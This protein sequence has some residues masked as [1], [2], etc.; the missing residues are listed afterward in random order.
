MAE[1][2]RVPRRRRH[3]YRPMSIAR[4]LA[5]RPRVLLAVVA[6]GIT[7]LLLPSRLPS[8]ISTAIAGDVAA[9]VYL[10]FALHAMITHSADKLRNRAAKEDDGAVVI[11]V[12][13]LVTIALSFGS[14]FGVLSEAKQ[15]SGAARAEHTALAAATILLSWLVTQVVFTFHYAHEFYRP[16]ERGEPMCSGLDFPKDG[17]PDYWDFFYFATSFGAASQ[18]S[19]VAISGKALRRIATLHAIVSFFFNTAVLALAINIGASLI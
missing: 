3:W 7:A 12:I 10:A 18:T 1:Q 16:D 2:P 19:D 8:S 11:L 13:V 17:K 6:G 14:I 9:L 4:S 5:I 15:M